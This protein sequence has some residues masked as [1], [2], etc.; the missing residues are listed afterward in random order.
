[1]IVMPCCEGRTNVSHVHD[2]PMCHMRMTHKC[3]TCA[4]SINVLQLH[5]RDAI[6]HRYGKYVKR[7]YESHTCVWK[8]FTRA[9]INLIY[10]H[11]LYD[12]KAMGWL[13]LVGSLKSYVSFAE[14]RLFY[15]A[16]VQKRPTILRSLL[17]VATPYHAQ[18][19]FICACIHVS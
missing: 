11:Y 16:L 17:I 19:R 9:L 3:V 6:P 14:Y 10:L 1:M 12:P 2:I 4:L 5:D 8:Y 13:R 15:R 7:A 18:V